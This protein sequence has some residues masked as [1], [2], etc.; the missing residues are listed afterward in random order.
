MTSPRAPWRPHPTVERVT[1]LAACAVVI[2]AA[3][4]MSLVVLSQLAL[5]LFPIIVATFLTR[6]LS[7]PAGWL[8]A[9]GWRPAP[10]AAT[11][12]LGFLATVAVGVSLI[13]PP[14]VEEFTG[15]GP[16]IRDGIDQVEG[17]I[18]EDSG[19]DITQQD[20]DDFKDD[21][22]ERGREQLEDSDDQVAAGA[23]AVFAAFAGLILALILT[24]FAVKDGPEFQRWALGVLPERHRSKAA[25]AAQAGWD[26][27]GGYLRGA[28]LLGIVEAIVIGGTMAILGAKLVIPV[29]VLTFVAAF[30]P[31]VGA[32][33][34]GV[35]AVLV[36]LATGSLTDAVIVAIVAVLVQQFDNDLLAP[37]IYGKAL[38]MHPVVILLSITTGTALF[39]WVGTIMA[40]PVTAVALSV[41]AALRASPEDGEAGDGDAE[42]PAGAATVDP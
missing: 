38:S 42:E 6:I 32:S 18:V 41:T 14:V 15:L 10:T 40:V 31:I 34:A 24:L 20:I 2:G 37:W 27:L 25:R 36:T 13:A 1:V 5:V 19:F 22:L 7:V 29:M 11:V 35:I 16:T 28:A 39:G 26:S 17:W 21:V 4:W 23:R 3:V 33:A 9:R 8:R 12:L 30:I